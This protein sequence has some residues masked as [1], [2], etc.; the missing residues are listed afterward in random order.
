MSQTNTRYMKQFL[1]TLGLTATE[2]HEQRKDRMNYQNLMWLLNKTAQMF[3]YENLPPTIPKIAFERLLQFCG[4]CVIWRVPDKYTPIGYG[5]SFQFTRNGLYLVD[6]APS[7]SGAPDESGK[8]LYAF[9]YALSD[10]PDPYDEPYKVTVTNPGFRPSISETLIINKDVIVIR[11]DTNYQGL[12]QLHD[13][14]A[15]LL[16]EAEISLQSTLVLLRDQMTFIVKNERQRAAVAAYIKA[17]EAGDYASIMAPELG[18]A[19]EAINHDGRSNAVELAVNGI[20]AIK[21]AWY[22]EIGLNPSFSLKR[23]Y[24]SAQEIDSNTDLLMPIIDDM[25]ENRRIG[26]EAVNDMFGTNISVK[27]SSAWKVKE[28]EIEAALKEAVK[29][30]ENAGENES[31]LSRDG[32]KEDDV[33]GDGDETAGGNDSEP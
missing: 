6:N 17:R 22:N 28:T 31:L 24:T 18:S 7:S 1:E 27:K 11:N 29:E 2:S 15:K 26:V 10:A 12:F 32:G 30:A 3:E 9:R 25:Y 21:A 20:Q 5:P 33:R 8:N 4:S 13:K 16:T 14:Y 23:E 19:L